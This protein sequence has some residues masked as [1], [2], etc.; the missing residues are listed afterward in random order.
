MRALALLLVLANLAVFAW[1]RYLSPTDAGLDRQPLSRQIEPDKLKIVPAA[2]LARLAAKKATATAPATPPATAPAAPAPVPTAAT[3]PAQAAAVPKP[4]SLAPLACLEWGSFTLTDAPK[5]EKALEP[6]ALGSRLAQRRTEELA[7]WW[8]F[9]PP[10]GSRQAAFKKAAELKKLGLDEFFIV[11]DEGPYRW[12]LSL[13]VFRNEDAAQARLATLRTQGVRSARVGPREMLVPKVWLQVKSVD[14][15]LE[16]RLKE[17]ARTV[18]G[19][20][21]KACPAP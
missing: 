14:A 16:A 19:S 17:I 20:E 11:G 2:E 3:P 1:W 10:Q 4:A 21:L 15:P 12:A 18:E 5:M 13:G 7:G 8:V 9:M 6:L